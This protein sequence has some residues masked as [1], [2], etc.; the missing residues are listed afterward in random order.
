[1][2]VVA[3]LANY[4]ST[5]AGKF[6]NVISQG[7]RRASIK[8]QLLFRKTPLVSSIRNGVKT[9]KRAVKVKMESLSE[10]SGN[11][12]TSFKS[13]FQS[14][15]AKAYKNLKNDSEFMET[16]NKY[17]TKRETDLGKMNIDDLP[18]AKAYQVMIENG[19][20][21]PTKMAQIV[22][23]NEKI[24]S[25]ISDPDLVKA[26][27]ATRSN[28]SFSRTFDEAQKVLDDAFPNQGFTLLKELSAGS[29]G[30]TYLVKRPNGSTAVLKMLKKGVDKE[31]LQ[32]EEKICNRLIKEFGDSSDEIVQLQKT[33]KNYYKDWADELNFA[34]EYANNKLLATGAKR[35]KVADI[36]HLSADGRCLI[37]DKA[38]GIQMNKLIEIMKSYKADPA[39]FATKYAK[40]ISANPW[41]ANPEKVAKD[42]PKTLLRTFDEQFMFA[43]KGGKSI[44]HG[45]PHTGNFFITADKKGRL[46]PE[47]IDTGNCVTRTSAQIKDDINFFTNYFVGNS[48]GVAN[49]FVKQ[50]G[51]TGANKT[52]LTK[53][54]ADDIQKTIF[55]GGQNITQFGTV[56]ENIQVILEKHGLKLST[57]NATAMKAQMQFFTAIGEAGS[58]TGRSSIDMSV[59]LKDIPRAT[60]DMARTGTN[61]WGAIKDAVKYAFNNVNSTVGNAYQFA[62]KDVDRVVSSTGHIS[63]IV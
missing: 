60:W 25:Q 51:Y 56:Q 11:L 15:G 37:M 46:I 16:W 12:V 61:P 54:I 28:C 21:G 9:A 8:T 57:E 29:V 49:Y 7:A 18:P 55:H 58:L 33:M 31:Q 38:N 42:L 14:K 20:V 3:K 13:R 22:S 63:T 48:Q 45:D 1:M 53:A 62:L 47:F 30:A 4:A 19:G 39:N 43:K 36:T 27:R 44:M 35:F 59:L 50:C 40:E 34:T 52:E 2:A 17:L 10:S 23:S 26:I 32:L 41:L 5:Y 6:T 24:M